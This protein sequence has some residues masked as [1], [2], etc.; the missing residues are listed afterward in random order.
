V[1]EREIGDRAR[2]REKEERERRVKEAEKEIPKE[3]ID[4]YRSFLFHLRRS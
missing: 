2:K 4:N 3:D 1:R